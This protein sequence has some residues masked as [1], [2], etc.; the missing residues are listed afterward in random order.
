MTLW[1]GCGAVDGSV[2]S[3]RSNMGVSHPRVNKSSDFSASY[4]S[5][6][7]IC[8]TTIIDWRVILLNIVKLKNHSEYVKYIYMLSKGHWWC[9]WRALCEQG[10]EWLAQGGSRWHKV[11]ATNKVGA[12]RPWEQRSPRMGLWRQEALLDLDSYEGLSFWNGNLINILYLGTLS[13]TF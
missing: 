10:T 13:K 9:P 12:P 4:F 7:P 11:G 8:C 5:S 1:P 3:L 2:P 6:H